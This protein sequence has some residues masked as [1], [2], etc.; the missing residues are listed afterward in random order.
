MEALLSSAEDNRQFEEPA[1]WVQALHTNYETLAYEVDLP[2]T[3]LKRK[4]RFQ[5][6]KVQNRLRDIHA[7]LNSV[8]PWFDSWDAAWL[9]YRSAPIS[10]FG[11]LSPSEVVK[12]YGNAGVRMVQKHIQRKKSGGFA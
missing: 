3:S 6:P 12:Q 1:L 5:S 7:I 10:G 11:G 4:D 2:V 8:S 9:W